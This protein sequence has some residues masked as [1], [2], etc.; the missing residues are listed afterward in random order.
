ML[1]HVLTTCRYSDKALA[2]LQDFG[3]LLFLGMRGFFECDLVPIEEAPD[4]RQRK[5][6]A[7]VGDQPLGMVPI[8]TMHQAKG[9]QFPFVFVG[10]MGEQ[11][12]VST[13]HRLESA[14]APFPTNATRSFARAPEATRAELDMIR[15]YYVA[16]SRAQ[17]ALVLMGTAQQFNRGRVPCGPGRTWLQ[18]KVYP[19]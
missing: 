3:A 8:M 14:L 6:L 1:R 4:H 18:S 17:W 9:L 13:A 10:H 15:Q 12:D 5:T 2:P 7:A 19:L 11:P 16:F